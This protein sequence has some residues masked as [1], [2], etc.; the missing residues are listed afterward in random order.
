MNGDSLP[1]PYD[2]DPLPFA[3]RRTAYARLHQRLMDPEQ[4]STVVFL[5]RKGIGKTVL[6]Q[7]FERDFDE[8]FIGAYSALT[9]DDVASET[10]W[11]LLLAQAITA[12]ISQRDLT[13]LRLAA[14]SPPE[15]DARAWF[16]TIFLAEIL[17]IIRG[18]RRLVLLLDDAECLMDALESGQVAPESITFLRDLMRETPQLGLALALDAAYEGE[19]ARLSPLVKPTDVLRL[20]SLLPGEATELLQKPVRGLYNV[21]DET[22]A[23]INRAT[24]GD[25]RLVQAFGRRLWWRW[26]SEPGLNVMTVD[27]VRTVTPLVYADVDDLLSEYWSGLNTNEQLVLTAFGSL[28]YDDPLLKIDGSALQNWLIE[29]DFPL[30]TTAVNVALRSLEYQE[31]IAQHADGLQ[32]VGELWQTWL[33]ER[34]R[35][36][37]DFPG[38]LRPRT[39]ARAAAAERTRN[40]RFLLTVIALVIAAVLLFAFLL[41]SNRDTGSE[42]APTAPTATLVATPGDA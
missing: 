27:D 19:L 23:A 24:G 5:G 15:D 21:P 6:L 20:T 29:T 30:D 31:I 8:T 37:G 17:A 35:T 1:N 11:W 2:G 40:L 28:R 34:A 13:L 16:Q 18:H 14:I 33:V 26:Q 42:S 7:N 39:Q 38:R 41:Q 10:G 36:S 12:A 25:P 3:G 4:A 22:A 32:L 9:A